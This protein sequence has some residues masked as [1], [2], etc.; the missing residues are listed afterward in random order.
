MNRPI[1]WGI[2]ATGKIAHKFAQGLQTLPDARPQ[3]VGSRQADAAHAFADTY[4]IP[5]RH[6][7]YEALAADPEVDIVYVA[8]P[9]NFHLE[10]A[11]LCLHH[12]KH[13]LC[14]KPLTINAQEAAIL[15]HTARARGLFLMEALWT[16]FLPAWV[17]VRQWIAEGLIGQVKLLRADFSLVSATFDPE[18]RKFNPHLAGGALLDVGI[19]PINAAYMVF[20]EDPAEVSSAAE[21]Y[22]TGV[23]VQSA[24]LF[25][26][27]SGA[28]AVL[29]SGFEVDGTKEALIQG[30][31]GTIRVPLFWRAGEV[32]VQ[33]HGEAPVRHDFGFE[34]T[35]LQYEA[36]ACMEA[37]RA[38]WLEHPQMPAAETLRIMRLMDRL[39]DTWGLRYPG[40]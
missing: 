38:G 5:H 32:I 13:V 33:L 34:A 1:R 16:R 24:Y 17:Q 21:M 31:L 6:A 9:H 23:D 22:S 18:D 11:L 30:T 37:L 27:R 28:I 35:G 14:E 26:Y 15:Y 3:A 40:E 2:L 25:R 7:S 12:G 4:G 19:Y 39:R 8:S 10:H 20:G 36:A 29:N